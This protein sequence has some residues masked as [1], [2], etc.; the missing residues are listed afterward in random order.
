MD[1]KKV[2]EI[3]YKALMQEKTTVIAGCTNT[4]TVLSARF[5][6]RKKVAKMVKQMMGRSLSTQS[7]QFIDI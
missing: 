5:M 3:G 7:D 4:L 2:A 1:S 6:P